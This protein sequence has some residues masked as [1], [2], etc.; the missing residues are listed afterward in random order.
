MKIKKIIIILVCLMILFVAGNIIISSKSQVDMGESNIETEKE[1]ETGENEP[2]NIGQFA[3]ETL[4]GDTITHDFFAKEKLTMINVWATFCGP[5]KIE[6][7]GLG[8]LDREIEDF[9]VMG[10]VMDVLN[11]DGTINTEQIEAAKELQKLTNVHYPSAILNENLA[12]LGFAQISSYPTTLFVDAEGNIVGDLVVGARD[13][14]DWR[15][16]IE[17]R[18]AAV[19]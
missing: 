12:R 13:E 6:M 10:V 3:A 7:P 11:Q 8:N 18:K 14:D 15:E 4:E 5:C 19:K 17:E 1:D 2:L 16:I 9:Q